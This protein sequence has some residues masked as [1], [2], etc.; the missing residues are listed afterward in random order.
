MGKRLALIFLLSATLI[1]LGVRESDAAAAADP[2][3]RWESLAPEIKGVLTPVA[4][5][6]DQM[7]GFQRKRLVNAAKNYPKLSKEEQARFRE[8]LPHWAKLPHEERK[9]ARETYKK[10]NSLPQEKREEIKKRWEE[11]KGTAP[12]TLTPAPAAPSSGSSTLAPA[13]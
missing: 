10:F 3:P 13:R 4:P 1:G 7:P 5:D 11:E 9:E 6:W 12:T 2:G 8:N